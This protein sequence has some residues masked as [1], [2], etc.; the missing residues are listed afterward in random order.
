MKAPKR[1]LCADKIISYLILNIPDGLNIE[2]WARQ[3][4]KAAARAELKQALHRIERISKKAVIVG[5]GGTI[6]TAYAK[7]K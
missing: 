6:I 1:Y 5:A 7:F 4:G 3:V 2:D